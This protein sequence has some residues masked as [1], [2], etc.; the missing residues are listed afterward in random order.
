MLCTVKFLS[1][2]HKQTERA[3]RAHRLGVV[4]GAWT[5]QVECGS[6]VI[7]TIGMWFEASSQRQILR[8]DSRIS[9]CGLSGFETLYKHNQGDKFFFKLVNLNYM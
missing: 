7:L 6:D 4:I 2:L 8:F 9:E 5:V 1:K 3:L